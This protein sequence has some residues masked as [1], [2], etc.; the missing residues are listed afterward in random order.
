MEDRVPLRL[1]Y[2]AF[3]SLCA[4]SESNVVFPVSELDFGPAA[5]LV[6]VFE[7][8]TTVLEARTL[9]PARLP[10][11]LAVPPE[12]V[13]ARVITYRVSSSDMFGREGILTS[14]ATGEALPRGEAELQ[15]ELD[16]E[17]DREWSSTPRSPALAA[18]RTPL[19]RGCRRFE[20]LPLRP[21]G[22]IGVPLALIDQP[23][24]SATDD[25]V[26][27]T[28]DGQK[29]VLGPGAGTPEFST[30]PRPSGLPPANLVAAVRTVAVAQYFFED[31][32]IAVETS[33]SWT[34]L[35][36]PR[37]PLVAAD[38]R[39]RLSGREITVLTGGG[40]LG[41]YVARDLSW[42]F[43]PVSSSSLAVGSA[44]VY[45]SR[46]SARVA[47][48]DDRSRTWTIA[49][50]GRQPTSI[51]APG[52]GRTLRLRDL[53][54]NHAFQY[55]TAEGEVYEET[56]QGLE[57]RVRPDP[58]PTLLGADLDDANED[59]R[60]F[61]VSA[62]AELLQLSSD[63]ECPPKPLMLVP[64]GL[65]EVTRSSVFVTG[66]RAGEPGRFLQQ[67]EIVRP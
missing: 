66:T 15:V 29:G 64:D 21:L 14:D 42:Q 57:L 56:T 34:H 30:I 17:G 39:T 45:M 65:V 26:L 5:G 23:E 67:L 16:P 20:S 4:C 46:T 1:A 27:V 49:E 18:F 43:A 31:G 47:V 13:S 54:P 48:L 44:T 28:R 33:T 24:F 60:R 50:Q 32:V 8:Q 11:V 38:A 61:A 36:S 3:A 12:A 51:E 2:L 58:K 59:V 63:F 22:M 35:R 25:L 19:A 10:S 7:S 6:L 40:D 52:S 62:E 9:D 55:V 53:K 41:F 37:V